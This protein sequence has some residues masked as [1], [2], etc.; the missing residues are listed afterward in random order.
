MCS[1]RCRGSS[2]T[3]DPVCGSALSTLDRV[4]NPCSA[5]RE[6]TQRIAKWP[7][8][9][10]DLGIPMKPARPAGPARRTRRQGADHAAARPRSG[11][12]GR[13][14]PPAAGVAAAARRAAGGGATQRRRGAQTDRR[15]RDHNVRRGHLLRHADRRGQ[16][17]GEPDQLPRRRGCRERSVQ[18]VGGDRGS[19][20]PRPFRGQPR[21]AQAADDPRDRAGLGDDPLRPDRDRVWRADLGRH[22]GA[23]RQRTARGH[24]ERDDARAR[25]AD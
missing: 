21:C 7:D 20:D 22:P 17:R 4:P 6:P 19:G 25:R 2:R 3:P 9:S 13:R 5:G 10:D 12:A 14:G 18:G 8:S 16:R 24:G 23:A 15:P 11:A 1:R